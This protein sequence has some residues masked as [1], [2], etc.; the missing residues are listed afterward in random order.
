MRKTKQEDTTISSSETTQPKIQTIKLNKFQKELLKALTVSTD[1]VIAARCGWGAGKSLGLILCLLAR[2]EIVGKEEQSLLVTDTHSRLQTV[3][4]PLFNEWLAPLGWVYSHSD[5]AFIAPNLHKCIVKSWFNSNTTP[6]DSVNPLEGINASMA[7]LDECQVFSPVIYSKVVGRVR[8][9][10]DP[11][12]IMV[13]L[14]VYDAWW[15]KVS[16]D[17]GYSPL[18]YSSHVNGE[19]L[20]E[21]WFSNLKT[22]P[23]SQRQAYIDNNPMPP[24]GQI[25]DSFSPY[26][27]VV[28]LQYDQRDMGYLAMDFGFRSPIVQLWARSSSHDNAFVLYKEIVEDSIK[29]T[30]L[31]EKIKSIAVSRKEYE[32]TPYLY[33]NHFII[34]K[35]CG[36]KAGTAMSDRTGK[37]TFSEIGT[38]LSIRPQWITDKVRVNILN[39]I[40]RCQKLFE[41]RLLLCS[42]NVW[43]E[44]VSKP[45]SFRNAI[46]NYKWKEGSG[47]EEA[48]KDD[49][50]DH[51]MDAMRYLVLNFLWNTSFQQNEKVKPGF[52]LPK[53][54]PKPSTNQGFSSPGMV[55]GGIS[56]GKKGLF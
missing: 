53:S 13:G 4:M 49:I 19:N 35:F 23:L 20:S 51:S 30:T 31:I 25:Y 54:S 6:N 33:P 16:T 15:V 38:A 43:E 52:I 7:L 44:G 46:S 41:D 1:T 28:D 48:V 17:A 5:S 56:F 45:K 42:T 40:Y 50:H 22:L 3:I 12:I 9:G 27:H 26:T 34:D 8:A 14:P 10:K 39:G 55:L 36:D 21:A 18:F 24:T 11:R 29:L 2:S 47:K 37:D 32:K